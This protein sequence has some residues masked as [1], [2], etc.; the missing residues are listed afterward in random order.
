MYAMIKSR[1][2]VPS[3]GIP[4]LEQM[5]AAVGGLIT[6]AFRLDSPCRKNVSVDVF[7]NDEGLCMNLPIDHVIKSNGSPV[8]GDMII[9]AVNENNGETIEATPKEIEAALNEIGILPVTMT[10]DMFGF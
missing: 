7:C 5:Q 8:A 10:P 9:V 2:L 3:V 6:T 4:T 1:S